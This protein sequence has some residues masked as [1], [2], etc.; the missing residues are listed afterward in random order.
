M[1]ARAAL[2]SLCLMTSLTAC[3]TTLKPEQIAQTRKGM[4]GS[5]TLQQAAELPQLPANILLTLR[6]DTAQDEKKLAVSGFSG[7]NHF[8][9]NA[10]V[11]WPQQQIVFGALATTRM[12]GPEPRMQFE[13][14]FLK[15]MGEVASFK[16]DEDKL[17]LKTLSGATLVFLRGA[18]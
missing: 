5:W 7:V 17:Q 8:V 14:A 15:Q 1:K 3:T 10:S 18:Q 16:L 2:L 13:Q 4:L 6:P 9:G 12:M 11:Q